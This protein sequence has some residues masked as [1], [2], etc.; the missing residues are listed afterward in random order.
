MTTLTVL[1]SLVAQ[2]GCSMLTW[3]RRRLTSSTT[4]RIGRTTFTVSPSLGD[5]IPGSLKACLGEKRTVR[6]WWNDEFKQN[7]L[8]RVN[9][10][11]SPL[12]YP[13]PQLRVRGR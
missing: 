7:V 5:K 8:L 3:D 11:R 2:V 13:Y 1:A 12:A 4:G 10:T 9:I 6:G